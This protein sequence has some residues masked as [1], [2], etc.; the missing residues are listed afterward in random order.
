M[1]EM[2]RA[3]I[4]TVVRTGQGDAVLLRPLGSDTSVPVFVGRSE[5]HSILIGGGEVTVRRPL[6]HDL[7]LDLV[8]QIGMALIRVEVHELKNNT[9]HARVVL[10]GREFSGKK[11]LVLDA[12]PS[13]AFALTV[14]RGCPLY[15][16]RKIVEQAGVPA[17]VLVKNPFRDRSAET[18]I[19]EAFPGTA[20]KRRGLEARLEEAVAAEEYERAAEIR[21]MLILLDEEGKRPI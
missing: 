2:L 16:A 10:A 11:P 21:D 18:A 9:F 13:D 15:I 7:F 1:A 14:R 8:G 17:D 19:R 20:G 12:R 4:W 6:T 3:E 5:V